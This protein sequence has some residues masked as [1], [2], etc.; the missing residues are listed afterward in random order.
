ELLFPDDLFTNWPMF[1]NLVYLKVTSKITFSMDTTLFNF[2]RISPNLVR[3]HIAQGYVKHLSSTDSGSRPDIV[4]QC[5]LLHL[6]LTFLK[7][8][9]V[10]QRMIIKFRSCIST[11]RQNNVMKKLLKF[12][13]GSNSCTIEVS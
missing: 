9:R 4:P 5:M 2:L 13:R 7:N 8:A 10:L 3:I 12:P 6:K 1:H 11:V